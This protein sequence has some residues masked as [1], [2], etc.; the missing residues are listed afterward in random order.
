[1]C[2]ISA[3]NPDFRFPTLSGELLTLYTKAYGEE[4]YRYYFEQLE[5][6]AL[7]LYGEDSVFRQAPVR[8]VESII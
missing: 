7:F 1:M 5:K 3:R 2:E 8:D 6:S 4:K